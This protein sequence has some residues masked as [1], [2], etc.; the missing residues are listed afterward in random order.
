MSPSSNSPQGSQFITK[1]IKLGPVW[2]PL[3]DPDCNSLPA[4]DKWC[5]LELTVPLGLDFF[6]YKVKGSSFFNSVIINLT[7]KKFYTMYNFIMKNILDCENLNISLAYYD[8]FVRKLH[9]TQ[10]L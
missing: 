5:D 1:F 9:Y 2:K 10:Y 8:L 7:G 3:H 4:T 6:I